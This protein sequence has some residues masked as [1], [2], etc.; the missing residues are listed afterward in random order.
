MT[1]DELV[2]WQSGEWQVIQERLDACAPGSFNPKREDLFAS[3]DA[4]PFETVKVAIIGQGPYPDATY[5]T[6]IAF[7]I[8]PSETRLPP[9]LLNIFK[10]Y[11]EDLH[12]PFPRT[13]DLR[14][15]A[16]Q[17]VLLWNA[18]PT[19]TTGSPASHRHWTEWTYLTKEIVEKLSEKG[20]IF[21][22]LGGFARNY[23]QYILL[24]T[25][26]VLSYSHPSPLGALKSKSP[27]LSSRLFSTV[28]AKLIEQKKE[29]IDWRLP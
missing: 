15:W 22:L 28:N 11:C 7:S 19:C 12:Y 2:F 29:P 3:L 5:A 13:G 27:F 16:S 20:I 24:S 14:D 18:M 26:V 6:G 9:T 21:V 10:V 17:G 1:W 4:T 23:L 8:P 25:N